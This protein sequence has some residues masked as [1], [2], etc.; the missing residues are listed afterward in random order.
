[1]NT[2]T[3]TEQSNL[4]ISVY[5]LNSTT[6]TLNSTPTTSVELTQDNSHTISLSMVPFIP[7]PP[8]ELYVQNETPMF[9]AGQGALWI[10]TGLGQDG[11]GITFWIE[12]GQ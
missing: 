1:M 9:N 5:S 11:T 8:N 10:Q 4:D 3:I 6:V 7:A 12:D 2:T